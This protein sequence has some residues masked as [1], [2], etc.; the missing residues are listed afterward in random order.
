[1]AASPAVVPLSDPGEPDPQVS[2]VFVLCVC[3]LHAVNGLRDPQF[4][5][6]L[7]LLLT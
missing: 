6:M 4:S 2:L 1:M 7:C 5:G 3:C